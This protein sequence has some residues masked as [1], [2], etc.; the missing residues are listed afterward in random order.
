MAS[1]GPMSSQETIELFNQYVVPNYGRFPV[2]LVRGEGSC[3]WDAEGNQ[4]LDLFP[5]TS[6]LRSNAEHRIDQARVPKLWELVQF[7]VD[8]D[9][10]V[11]LKSEH[12]IHAPDAALNHR[13][14]E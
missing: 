4:Y 1:D 7:V 11:T 9:C 3:V 8:G 6:L 10:K 2:S 14:R 5:D 13:G 12:R